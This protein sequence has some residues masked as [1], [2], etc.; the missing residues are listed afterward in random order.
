MPPSALPS[1]VPRHACHGHH[2]AYRCKG[3]E[4]PF[5]AIPEGI[6]VHHLHWVD[7]CSTYSKEHRREFKHPPAL[8]GYR[9]QKE[10]AKLRNHQAT[11]PT[12]SSSSL[13]PR[14]SPSE[15]QVVPAAGVRKPTGKSPSPVPDPDSKARKATKSRPAKA[16]KMVD[17]LEAPLQPQAPCHGTEVAKWLHSHSIRPKAGQQNFLQA[18]YE[19]GV[20]T[21]D[22]L[23]SLALSED[24]WAALMP[25][26][27]AR[28]Q[29]AERL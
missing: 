18:L 27:V 17:E 16:I 19:D 21:L 23:R 7:G 24:D 10:K 28:S 29:V 14:P 6:C 3:A 26:K 5:L 11:R 12:V 25:S 20:H 8:Q 1:G 22:D 9:D 13:V 15:C 4:C 2:G